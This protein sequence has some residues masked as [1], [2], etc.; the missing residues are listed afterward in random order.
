MFYDEKGQPTTMRHDFHISRRSGDRSRGRQPKP[1]DL[2]EAARRALKR[3]LS[4]RI[5]SGLEEANRLGQILDRATAEIL[6]EPSN[7]QGA[8]ICQAP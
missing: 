5:G 8:L 7:D 1:P 3:A 6:A 2:V 4:E